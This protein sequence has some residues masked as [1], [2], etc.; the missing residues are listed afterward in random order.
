VFVVTGVFIA[1][2]ILHLMLLLLSGARRD[3]EATFRVVSYAQATSILFLVPFCGTLVGGVWCLVLY[4]LGLAAV[5]QIGHGRA[6]AA[7]LLP[8]ALVCCCCALLGFFFA[9]TIAGLVG[10]M[11]QMR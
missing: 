3:F 1:A 2:G 10:Q 4:V 5:H 8:I 7:V 6:T 9:A 11:G